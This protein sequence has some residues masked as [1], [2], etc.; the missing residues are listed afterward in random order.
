MG[1]Y[2]EQPGMEESIPSSDGGLQQAGSVTNP[3]ECLHSPVGRRSRLDLIQIIESEI[4]PR[5]FLAHRDREAHP[6]ACTTDMAG[7]LGDRLFLARLF[8]LGNVAEIVT[9]LQAV[10]GN[11]MPRDRIYIDLLAPVPGT[12]SRLWAEGQFS[13]DEIAVGLCCVDEVL[14]RLHE[15]EH[16]GSDSD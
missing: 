11:G 2:I 9:R 3:R 7:D 16:A 14:K 15:L 10:L 6:L 1:L 13:F 4:I 8:V 5:L 12:L